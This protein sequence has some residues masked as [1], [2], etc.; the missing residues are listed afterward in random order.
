[1]LSGTPL[2]HALLI[3]M[4]AAQEFRKAHRIDILNTIILSDGVSHC[5]DTRGEGLGYNPL[6]KAY[7]NKSHLTTITCP[8]NNKTYKYKKHPNRQSMATDLL[9][10]M[11]K[12]VTGSTVIGYFIERA[13]QSAFE[14]S[15]SLMTGR[16]AS[17]NWDDKDKLKQYRKNG[18]YNVERPIGYDECYIICDKSL[19]IADS[20]MDDLL[21]DATKARIK[22]A[23][24]KSM[25][26]SKAS[27]KM[28]SDLVTKCS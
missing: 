12:D 3:G 18:W 27:R 8:H 17:Q 10:E 14:S 24:T 28:L 11:Y 19:Q 1:M 4:D 22:S 6:R 13:T 20:K 15:Y 7:T 9:L 23:F 2:D 21:P 5:L 26:G 16:S 25:T